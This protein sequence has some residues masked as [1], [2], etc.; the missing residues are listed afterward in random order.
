LKLAAL[1]AVG[2]LSAAVIATILSAMMTIDDEAIEVAGTSPFGR[3]RM[4]VAR[5]C[6]AATCAMVAGAIPAIVVA[7][8]GEW[9]AAL[10]SLVSTVIAAAGFGW[11]G[12]CSTRS[13]SAEERARAAGQPRIS[14]QVLVAMLLGGLH[15]A[16]PGIYIGTGSLVAAMLAAGFAACLTSIL[17]LV[18]PRDI[19]MA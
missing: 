3:R 19:A 2:P 15:A 13:V 14:G 6:A 17:F 11:F 16:G 7:A 9:I 8:T 10:L 1:A 4:F 12:A 18:P 5:A